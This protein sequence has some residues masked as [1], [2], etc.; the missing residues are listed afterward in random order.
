MLL[1]DIKLKTLIVCHLSAQ[2]HV[3]QASK[4]VK[5]SNLTTKNSNTTTFPS[6]KLHKLW[7]DMDT[8]NSRVDCSS[9]S[10]CLACISSIWSS[11]S[12]IS[13]DI[14]A[15]SC[16]AELLQTS[17]PLTGPTASQPFSGTLPRS[18]LERSG[19]SGSG[20]KT[21]TFPVQGGSFTS[22]HKGSSAFSFSSNGP[23]SG[24]PAASTLS[25]NSRAL[26]VSRF[27]DMSSTSSAAL[28]SRELG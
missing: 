15:P 27:T 10:S 21:A 9:S 19:S 2:E 14:Q 5:M 23:W 26:N 4:R 1:L 18:S 11:Y 7:N 20:L 22:L 6:V 25:P 17:A 28:Q 13:R 12:E 8:W 16:W 3:Q 24:R